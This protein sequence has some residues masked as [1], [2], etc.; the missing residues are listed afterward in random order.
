[1]AERLDERITAQPEPHPERTNDDNKIT[2]TTTALP[3]EQVVKPPKKATRVRRKLCLDDE[4]E[5]KAQQDDGEAPT[6]GLED[7]FIFGLKPKKRQP[8]RK[9]EDEAVPVT[10]KGTT[11]KAP[12]KGRKA[13]KAKQQT[14]DKRAFGLA[15]EPPLEIVILEE[16]VDEGCV[17]ELPKETFERAPAK[18]KKGT[19]AKLQAEGEHM[20]GL[21]A[22][23]F[24]KAVVPEENTEKATAS[25][26]SKQAPKKATKAKQQT[27]D[28]HM[29]DSAAEAVVPEKNTEKTTDPEVAK[30]TSKKAPCKGNKAAKV[31]RQAEDEPTHLRKQRRSTKQSLDLAI[32]EILRPWPRPW[33]MKQRMQSLSRPRQRQL[34]KEPISG[35]S[36]KS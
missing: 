1:L 2:I 11:K 24:A 34:P 4:I 31:K 18:K 27:E 25:E 19:K 17:S 3:S 8:R 26:A 28:V 15:A 32:L 30:Q 29:A 20:S 21:A 22:E 5:Q 36:M 6:G 16:N 10:S 13:N 23:P 33:T 12:A 14:E 9:L 35:R 7:T